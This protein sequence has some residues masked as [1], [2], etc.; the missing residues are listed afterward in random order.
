V[1]LLDADASLIGQLADEGERNTITKLYQKR[2]QEL[3]GK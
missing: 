3:A 1:D 2:R